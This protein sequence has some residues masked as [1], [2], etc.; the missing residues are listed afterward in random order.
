M[1]EQRLEAACSGT[2]ELLRMQ[3]RMSQESKA[4]RERW[5]IHRGNYERWAIHRGNYRGEIRWSRVEGMGCASHEEAHLN[6]DLEPGSVAGE[7]VNANSARI[8]ALHATKHLQSDQIASQA[9]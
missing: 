8:E 2:Q 1:L 3:Y 7:A 5:A 4:V 9:W 6:V